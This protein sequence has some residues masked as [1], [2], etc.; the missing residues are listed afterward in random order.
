[1]TE[2]GSRFLD[3]EALQRYKE[4]LI[5]EERA[6]ATVDKYLH[7]V[8]VFEAFVRREQSCEAD[9]NSAADTIRKAVT[10]EKVIE[11]KRNLL[12]IYHVRSVNSMLAA[13]NSF[14]SFMDWTDFRVKPVKIQRQMFCEE[15]R[16]LNKKEYYRLVRAAQNM[17]KRQL[18]LILQTLCGLGL[19][20]SELKSV[21]V[22]SVRKGKLCIYN[23]GK[24]RIVFIGSKLQKQLLL[25]IRE[26]K[27]KTGEVF[28]TKTGKGVDRSNVWREMKKLCGEADVEW[29][30]IFPHNLRH[31]FARTFYELKKDVVKLADIM[32]HSSIETT[33]IYTATSGKEYRRQ[34]ELLGLVI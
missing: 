18:S 14:F 26:R 23:K 27:L 15:Q 25:Y 30:K 17:G 10:K 24:N 11:F 2:E 13:L 31:L 4:Y 7:D 9:W 16:E 6:E 29:Q 28:I 32:G 1:M 21:T 22:E 5:K 33:R 20:I 8:R 12:T 3:K 34:M 19:R